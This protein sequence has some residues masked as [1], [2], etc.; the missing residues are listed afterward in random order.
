MRLLILSL[1]FATLGYTSAGQELPKREFRGVWIATVQNIDWPPSPGS[2]PEAAQGALVALLDQ[3]AAAG[4][5][6]VIL[7]VRPE[8]D[9]LYE[10][11]YEPWSYWLSGTQGAPPVPFYDPLAF[12][13]AE[14]HKRGMEIHAWFNPYRAVQT[15]GRYPAAANHVSVQHPEW[16][17]TIGSLKMLDPGLDAVRQY[18]AM[19]ITDVARRYDVDGVHMDDYF[20]AAGITNQDSASYAADPRGLSLGDWRRD[21]VNRLI[22]R[23][24]DSVLAVKP[25]VK[26]GM[27][28]AGIW[29]NGVPPGVT[30][31]DN[32]SVIYCDA[33]AWLQ[34]KSIDYIA[35]QLYWKFGG[36][37][38]YALLQPWWASQANGRHLY[39][40]LADYRI[41]Q[42]SFGGSTMIAS[43]IR[44]NR[45]TNNAQGSIQY[46]CNNITS[47]NLGGIADTLRTSL[48][49]YPALLPVM[50]WKDSIPPYMPRGIHYDAIAGN[51]PAALQWEAP[52]I[53]PDGD[54]ASR[55]AVYRFDHRPAAGEIDD[56]KNLLA[57]AGSRTFVPPVPA[58]SGTYY[59][60][61]TA[62]DRNYNESDTSTIVV[63]SPQDPPAPIAPADHQ[64]DLP[65]SVTLRWKRV[66]LAS[67][68]S[69]QVCN[70][71]TFAS[72][73]FYGVAYLADTTVTIRGLTGQVPYFWRL[74]S[75]NAAGA[76]PPGP[77]RSFSSAVPAVAALQFPANGADKVSQST[78]L[79]WSPPQGAGTYRVQVAKASDFAAP[80]VDS[81]A[82]ADTTLAVGPLQPSTIYFWRVRTS[83]AAGNSPWSA[84]F[85]FRTE[86]PS[87]VA[88]APLR[89]DRF[90]LEPNYP[91]PFNPTTT[92]RYSIPAAGHVVLTVYDVLGREVDVLVNDDLAPGTYEVRWIAASRASGVYFLIMRSGSFVAV[93]R[94][95]LVK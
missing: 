77:Y 45:S 64:N 17:L 69:V 21:N 70:D 60:L 25:W 51:G 29:K 41:G 63:V 92:I 58:A 81:S 79:R 87:A 88:P 80:V 48:F 71:S 36:N 19:I 50:A 24:E 86:T 35:P 3:L 10:S 38:D 74:G 32:Y 42:S 52:G 16:I 90:S 56:T 91:N 95:M 84:V 62:L 82:V 13:V 66:P 23:I 37:Q 20:Y 33:V 31:Q 1:V 46:T 27:S 14:A 30:G 4:V 59:Y 65:D 47:G 8:C 53:A 78:A 5:N 40:G 57:V 15:V 61:T 12:A 7:Q 68:Y 94:M 18:V 9:A 93:D 39:P 26:F 54:S 28:P 72:P 6:A 11:P 76:S 2:S 34:S 85:R 22:R 89:P 75:N 67:S 83:N 43:Q 44:F 55:Y 49:K 73:L